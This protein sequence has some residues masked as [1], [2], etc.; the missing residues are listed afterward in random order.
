MVGSVLME[1]MQTEKDFQ[2]FEPIF[3][4]TSQVGQAGPDVGYGSSPLEDAMNI[5]RLAE[6]DII[7]SCQGGDTLR[8]SM[9]RSAIN[10]TAT[11]LTQP[12]P[13]G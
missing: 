6:M 10:G 3:F 8:R 2:G 7:L 5:N 12:Q 1:R 13:S 11:G 4:T 9:N